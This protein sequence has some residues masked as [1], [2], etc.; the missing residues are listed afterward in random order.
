[1]SEDSDWKEVHT[2]RRQWQTAAARVEARAREGR[3]GLA[4]KRAGGRGTTRVSARR[5][6]AVTSGHT[7]ASACALEAGTGRKAGG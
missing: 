2:G 4:Y 6:C 7:G 5:R 3:P 1:V